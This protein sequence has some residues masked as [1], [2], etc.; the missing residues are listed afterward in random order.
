M[1]EVKGILI[2]ITKDQ[3]DSIL[4]TVFGFIKEKLPE[5][6]EGIVDSLIAGEIHDLG[7]LASGG[8]LDKAKG[9]LEG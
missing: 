3:I 4:E 9:L 7:D 6:T 5:G 1:P 8:L 2:G